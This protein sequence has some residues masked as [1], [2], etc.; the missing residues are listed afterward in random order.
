M[1]IR[2]RTALA[3]P[4]ARATTPGAR[5]ARERLA[6]L[7]LAPALAACVAEGTTPVADVRAARVTLTTAAAPLTSLGDTAR[8]SARVVD[9]A[10]VP[11]AAAPLRWRVAP[12]GVVHADADGVYRAVG[13]GRATVVAEL[14]PGQTGV[15]PTGYWAGRLVDS[16]VVEVRQ[17]PARLTLAPVDTAF[18]ALG[19]SRQLRVDVTD[20]RGHALLDGPPPLTWWSADPRTATV[21][22]AGVV[23]GV[24]E[25]SARVVVQADSLRGWA[26]FT[27]SP[28][29]PHTSC[30][31]FAQRRQSRQACVTLDFVVREPG[32]AR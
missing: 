6:V 24:G 17:R 31:V 27:V 8:V 3:R 12:A 22:G 26:T 23:R 9:A 15:R 19:A 10:G 1:T 7:A 29:M 30:M 13:N 28:R 18:R 2:D 21:D 14:D 32:G 20:R 16:V 4:S 25:G 11:L 5:P